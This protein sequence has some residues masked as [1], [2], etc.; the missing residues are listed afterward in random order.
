MK[1]KRTVLLSFLM[2]ISFVAGAFGANEL[3]EKVDAIIR[4]DYQ[5]YFNGV[6]ANVGDIL[7]YKDKS[8]LLLDNIGKLLD[9]EI[10][11]DV[12]A[13]TIHVKKQTPT[14]NPG[15]TPSPSPGNAQEDP[16]NYDTT[17]LVYTSTFTFQLN[18]REYPVF[19]FTDVNYKLYYRDRDLQRANIDTSKARKT[20]EAVTKEFYVSEAELKRI[21]SPL[22]KFAPYY[23][24]LVIGEN[25]PERLQA[26]IDYIEYLPE[27]YRLVNNDPGYY[28]PM[29]YILLIERLQD[30]DY[31]V[32]TTEDQNYMRYSITM[33]LNSSNE[34]QIRSVKPEKLGSPNDYSGYY[35]F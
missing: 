25:D 29:P 33:M 22:P 4:H 32:L 26:V 24:R 11:F 5:L 6:K 31:V 23:N 1:W 19:A 34:W 9:A 13:K 20:K 16:Q 28:Y 15:S 17:A 2:L 10:T 8:Y 21:L 7:I 35:S 27:F 12:N 30:N 18:G 3:V 14:S